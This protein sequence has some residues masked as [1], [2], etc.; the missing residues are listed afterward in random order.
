M[1]KNARQ[2]RLR[3]W[4]ILELSRTG[5]GENQFFNDLAMSIS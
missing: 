4:V 2:S 3:Y 1:P 5:G